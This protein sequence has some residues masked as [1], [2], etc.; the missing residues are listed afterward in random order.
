MLISSMMIMT[1]IE[2][3]YDF[4]VNYNYNIL[5]CMKNNILN[6]NNYNYNI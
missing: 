2:N 1:D 3:V 4:N 6:F 5:L